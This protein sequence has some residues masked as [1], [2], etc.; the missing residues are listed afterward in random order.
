LQWSP[1]NGSTAAVAGEAETILSACSDLFQQIFPRHPSGTFPLFLLHRLVAP[2]GQSRYAGFQVPL[3]SDKQSGQGPRRWAF[4]V[5]AE[6]IVATLVTRTEEIIRLGSP[7][8]IA[9]S[10]SAHPFENSEFSISCPEDKTRDAAPLKPQT[11]S[12][13]KCIKLHEHSVGK[14]NFVRLA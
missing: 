8:H 9:V 7:R 5:L 14:L 3:E 6:F 2:Y 11:A 10:M 13:F 4:D 1:D 12:R